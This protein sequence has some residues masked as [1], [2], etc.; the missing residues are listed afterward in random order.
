[1]PMQ[2]GYFYSRKTQQ[3]V[4]KLA[5]NADLYLSFVIRTSFYGINLNIKKYNYAV[6]SMFLNYKKS[7]NN[8]RSFIWRII[9]KIELPLLY[10]AEKKQIMN[11]NLTSFVNK[12]EADYWKDFGN[13]YNL[14][15]G[16]DDKIFE[17]NSI[18]PEYSKCI[19]FIGRMDYQPN[20]D[21]VLWFCENVLNKINPDITFLLIGGFLDNKIEK[22]LLNYNN[23]KYLGFVDDPNII[24]R[25]CLC[26]IATMQTGG[27][28]Q[29]KIL[30]AMGLGSLVI[31]TS[32]S[33]A[34]IINAENMVNLIIE[35]NP[36]EITKIINS[37]YSNESDYDF[38]KKNARQLIYD[39]YSNQKIKEKLLL[40]INKIL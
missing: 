1:M 18:D 10:K 9:Y 8:S 36:I 19:A 28:L 30:L 23:F 25:S 33:A 35:D 20:I 11:F 21:A 29:T 2:V 7:L 15:H 39:N 17:V 4:D 14:P 37:I 31:T 40:Q 12:D 26:N 6:D 38:I 34:P 16:L 13:V 27:G 32:A 3:L 5:Q 22:R 24:L